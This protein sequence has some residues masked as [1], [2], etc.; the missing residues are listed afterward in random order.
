MKYTT[1]LPTAKFADLLI[2]L[3]EEGVEG[4]PPS[5]G[6]RDSLRAALIYMRHNVIQAVIGEQPGASQPTISRAIK[7]LTR[8]L[9]DLLLTAEEVPEGCDFRG[10]RRPLPLLKLAESPRIAVAVSTGRPA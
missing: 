10:G 7:A 2:R 3:R 4:Y 9:K 8:A 5:P 1:G 6:L